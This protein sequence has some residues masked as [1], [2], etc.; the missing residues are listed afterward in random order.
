MK[1]EDLSLRELC[2]KYH[3]NCQRIREI[4]DTCETENRM[5][6]ESEEAEYTRLER[7]NQWYQMRANALVTPTMGTEPGAADSAAKI[8][9]ENAQAGRQTAVMFV[10]DLMMV[11]DAVAGGLVPVKIQDIVGPLSEGLILDKV[12]LPLMTGLS[13]DYVWPVVEA[14]EAT[15]AGEGVALTDTKIPLSKLTAQPQRIGVAIPVTRQSLHKTEGLI[16]TIVKQLMPLAISRLVNKVMFSTTKVTGA[17][18]LAGPFASI[19]AKDYV[20]LSKVPTFKE[21]VLMKA[22][23][24]KSGVDGDALCYVMTKSMKAILEAT[25]KDPGSGI[26]VCEDDKIAG[27]PVF[28]TNYIGE[29]FIGCG[30]WRYQPTGF[31]GAMSFVIDPYSQA[32]KDSVDFVLNTDCATTTLLPAAF[33]LGK[34]TTTA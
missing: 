10:R 5:R 34:V 8:I 6:S 19:A 7:E 1:K 23:V 4:A 12:G 24:L 16:E 32:R 33:V 26:M 18:T 9:R 30:D 25:P 13:G 14:V 27:V 31:F 17:T 2:N 11:S 28:T 29:N 20:T 22:Q 21:L 15:I 3:E